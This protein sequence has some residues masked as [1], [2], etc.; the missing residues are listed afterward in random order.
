MSDTVPDDGPVVAEGALERLVLGVHLP[1]VVE[2]L[3]RDAHLAAVLAALLLRVVLV[4]H[5]LVLAE[6][7]AVG[8]ALAALKE[9][10]TGSGIGAQLLLAVCR[11]QSPVL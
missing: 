2:R 7:L 3:H 8:K 11:A 10:Q 5:V 4:V 6:A 9:T 1:V